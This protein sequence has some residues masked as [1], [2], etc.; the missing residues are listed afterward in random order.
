[1]IAWEGDATAWT[2]GAATTAPSIVVRQ[3]VEPTPN[4]RP[5]YSPSAC[6][7]M[8]V[9]ITT[10]ANPFATPKA[11]SRPSAARALPDQAK[12]RKR[13]PMAPSPG[14]SHLAST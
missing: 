12:A 11:A 1:M 8:A 13:Q 6:W 2:A 5:W 4:T 7:W 9:V 10:S 14:A 3:I